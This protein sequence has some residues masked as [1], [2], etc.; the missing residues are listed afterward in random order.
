MGYLNQCVTSLT[1]SSPEI[2]QTNGAQKII[3][4]KHLCVALDALSPPNK[5]YFQNLSL[6]CKVLF[7]H[8][9]ASYVYTGH[10]GCNDKK[11]VFG[12]RLRVLFSAAL[13]C[14]VREQD[15]LFTLP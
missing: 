7:F 12:Y 14:C 15:T 4:S 8:I 6:Y 9:F 13:I 3:S 10:I 11:S 2:M 5:F 1:A